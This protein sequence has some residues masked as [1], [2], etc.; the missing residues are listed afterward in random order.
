MK[1]RGTEKPVKTST[2]SPAVTITKPKDLQNEEFLCGRYLK[3]LVDNVA[4]E[5]D[6]ELLAGDNQNNTYRIKY[7]QI[8]TFVYSVTRR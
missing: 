3:D 8:A 1:D 6:N 4:P 5:V 2:T 7:L